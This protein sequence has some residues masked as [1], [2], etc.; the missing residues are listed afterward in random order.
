MSSDDAIDGG[1]NDVAANPEYRS[2]QP[3]K[4]KK[5]K[6]QKL[7]PVDVYHSEIVD[8]YRKLHH[9]C[10]KQLHKE[11]KLV[12]SF[13]CQKIVRSIKSAKES[14]GGD[15]G[16]VKTK[17]EERL[18]SRLQSLEC[19]LER[20]KRMNLD[21]P[22]Q[23]ALKR[24]GV[25]NLDPIIRGKDVVEESVAN[26]SDQDQFYLQLTETML[27]HK[28]LSS[29]MDQL[30]SKV[31]D[32]RQWSTRREGLLLRKGDQDL[33]HQ[34][35]KT[36]TK[37]KKAKKLGTK[38]TNDTM[39]VAGGFHGRKRGLDLGGH[40]GASG[41]FIGSLSGVAANDDY[42][43]S[44][45]EGDFDEHF[46]P[47]T[48]RKKNRPGQRSRKAKALA[49]EAKKAGKTWDSSLNWRE[50]KQEKLDSSEGSDGR[51]SNRGGAP[52]SSETTGTNRRG[53]TPA[54]DD[55]RKEWKD[56]G[57]AHPSWTAANA[58]KPTIQAFKGKKITFD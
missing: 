50:K 16:V 15:G 6:R 5:R 4:N 29:A 23:T 39:I 8:K 53:S 2:R 37:N 32:F 19:K 48:K 36:T 45:T 47:E 12:K 9:A 22:V 56:E 17:A 34:D 7:S 46:E 49:I 27:R 10:S 14:I 20:T 38:S 33:E 51:H 18:Q 24:L 43:W 54:D 41:I 13:E 44:G 26:H 35:R 25:S 31:A 52:R 57:N 40:E 58:N 28:R 21:A 1:S 55:P 42:E 3:P 11:A 30:N